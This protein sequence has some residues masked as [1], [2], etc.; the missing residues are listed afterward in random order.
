MGTFERRAHGHERPGPTISP[1]GPA[2]R[3]GI[4]AGT[5]SGVFRSTDD[6]AS[7]TAVNNGLDWPFIDAL[8]V[9]ADGILFAGTTEGGGVY[10]STDNGGNRGPWST[11]A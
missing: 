3:P 6:G 7:W 1:D 8:A 11:T 5:F 4:F 10:R 2:L 9:N